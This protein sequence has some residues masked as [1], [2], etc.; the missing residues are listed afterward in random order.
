MNWSP[1]GVAAASHQGTGHW[2]S[3]FKIPFAGFTGMTTAPAT[4]SIM[5]ALLGRHYPRV[6]DDYM[7]IPA[8]ASA[9]LWIAIGLPFNSKDY[10]V[11]NVT[12]SSDG[13]SWMSWTAANSGSAPIVDSS[14]QGYDATA[15]TFARVSG[16]GTDKIQPWWGYWMLVF[17]GKKLDIK[18]QAP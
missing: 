3:E 17:D 8:H 5:G 6:T 9:P 13:G 4:N 7:N 14:L 16:L 18:F 11:S 2:Y 1:D 15:G 10:P 12:F